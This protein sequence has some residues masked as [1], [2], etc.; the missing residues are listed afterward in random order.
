MGYQ[1]TGEFVEACDCRLMCPCWTDDE[2]D[3]GHCTGLFA[4]TLA[5]GSTIDGVDVGGARVVCVTAHLGR[6]RG[7]SARETAVSVLFVDTTGLSDPAAFD[8]LGR[9]FSGQMLGPLADLAAVN[10]TVVLV[11]HA[12]VAVTDAGGT[13]TVTDVHGV[14]PVLAVLDPARFDGL[15]PL[16]L[17]RTALSKE[18][19]I[20][21]QTVTAHHS[22]IT[23][24]TA[25]LPGGF[26]EVTG[27]SGMR[28]PFHYL[29]KE[30][31]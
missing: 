27:R 11:D 24:H 5:G 20:A 1:L 28:G 8:L 10:G 25:V 17:Q 6:R 26:I 23:I 29:H 30:S 4:W 16:T 15:D 14:Q 12:A 9:A 7:Q 21:D 19:G 31:P 2:P 18:L 3:D 13:V 22:D